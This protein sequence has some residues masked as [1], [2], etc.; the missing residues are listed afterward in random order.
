MAMMTD[1]EKRKLLSSMTLW[2]DHFFT[3]CFSGDRESASL[4]LKVL[5]DRDDL[6]VGSVRTQEWIESIEGHSVRLDVIA[7]DAEGNI[8]NIEIQ[9][10]EGMA[11]RKRARY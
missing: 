10:D 11:K 8:Y 9:K 3:K 4:L 6:K 5:L 2:N 1:K 7:N